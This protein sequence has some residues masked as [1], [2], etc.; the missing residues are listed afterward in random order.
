MSTTVTVNIDHEGNASIDVSGHKGPSCKKLVEPLKKALGG[1]AAEDTL[2]PEYYKPEAN[3]NTLVNH[4][5]IAN[6]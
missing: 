6:R 2:K 5:S 4:G 1:A 3:R